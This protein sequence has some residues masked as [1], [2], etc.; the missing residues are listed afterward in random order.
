M[1]LQYQYRLIEHHYKNFYTYE[2]FSQT[3]ENVKIC[4]TYM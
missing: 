2:N 4:A 1:V 3:S